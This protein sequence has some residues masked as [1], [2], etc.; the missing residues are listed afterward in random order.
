MIWIVLL[1]AQAAVP[2]QT[3]RGQAV[4]MDSQKGCVTCHA[5]KGQGTAVGPDLT[6]IGR[7]APAAIAMGVRSTATQYVQNVTLKSGQFFPAMPG[8][9]DEKGLSLYDLSKMPPELQVVPQS[10]IASMSGSDKWRHPP[11]SGKL[12]DQEIAD[13]IAYV[14]YAATGTKKAVDPGEVK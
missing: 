4:F 2:S 13:V 3:D 5:L 7:L 6:G 8:K 9:K 11:A 12:T 14:R 1:M 10:D